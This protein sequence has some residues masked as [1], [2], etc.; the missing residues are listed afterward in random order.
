MMISQDKSTSTT[1]ETLK[2]LPL[3]QNA[4]FNLTER[5]D[6]MERL[7]LTSQQ[8]KLIHLTPQLGQA[9]TI[10]INLEL[11][12]LD[13]NRALLL[14]KLIFYQEMTLMKEMNHSESNCL[15]S[16]QKELS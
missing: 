8:K 10:N 11:L 6:P 3:T 7:K 9:L 5:M 4:L 16:V 2:L 13:I 1:P 14:L 15:I 12:H